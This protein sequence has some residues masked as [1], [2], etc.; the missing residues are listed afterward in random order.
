M[1]ASSFDG[2]LDGLAPGCRDAFGI[3]DGDGHASIVGG[4]R[5][6][7]AARRAVQA[8]T[9]PSNGWSQGS[10]TLGVATWVRRTVRCFYW[11]A[12]DARRLLDRVVGDEGELIA[13]VQPLKCV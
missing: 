13:V 5:E 4:L 7:T 8:R 12:F 6:I 1:A 9:R 2:S 11:A 10:G 3:E